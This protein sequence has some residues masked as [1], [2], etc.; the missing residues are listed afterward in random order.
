[1]SPPKGSVDK[2]P[3]NKQALHVEPN[4]YD[5]KAM[6]DA[7]ATAGTTTKDKPTSPGSPGPGVAAAV[8]SDD[9]LN[10]AEKRLWDELKDLI[11]TFG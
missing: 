3:A 1:M 2:C 9:Q 5:T 8:A 7:L 4:A 10:T 11:A 6:A